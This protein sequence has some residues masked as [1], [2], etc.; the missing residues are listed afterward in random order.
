MAEKEHRFTV[1]ATSYV[2]DGKTPEAWKKLLKEREAARKAAEA[3][4]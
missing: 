2:V 4:E 1:G 3:S